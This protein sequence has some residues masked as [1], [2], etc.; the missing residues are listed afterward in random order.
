MPAGRAR[1]NA[2]TPSPTMSSAAPSTSRLC[3]SHCQIAMPDRNTAH[4]TANWRSVLTCGRKLMSDQRMLVKLKLGQ[5]AFASFGGFLDVD[6]RLLDYEIF[7]NQ[8]IHI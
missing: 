2:P 7:Q 5:V 4:N 3:T 6:C 8:G 1:P